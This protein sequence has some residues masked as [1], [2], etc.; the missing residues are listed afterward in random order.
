MKKKLSA[1][2]VASNCSDLTDVRE[3]IKE[4]QD[5]ILK[6]NSENKN[7]PA[8]FFSRLSKLKAKKEKFECRNQ[9]LMNVNIRFYVDETTLEMAVRHC[10]YFKVEP[11]FQNVGE[12]IKNAVRNNGKSIIDFPESWGDELFEVNKIEVDKAFRQLKSFFGL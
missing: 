8:Y 5:A 10:L 7:V 1:Y 2:T 11:T 9:V 3:G 4:I 12:A 6:I